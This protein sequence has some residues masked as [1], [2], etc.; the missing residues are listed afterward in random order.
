[1]LM[2]FSSGRGSAGKCV[3][4]E[5]GEVAMVRFW[6]RGEDCRFGSGSRNIVLKVSWE[7]APTEEK[8]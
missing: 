5:N 4:E 3:V 1:M 7:A 8:E 2:R 6:L